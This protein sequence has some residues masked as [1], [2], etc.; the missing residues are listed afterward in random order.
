MSLES[1]RVR[2]SPH[3]FRISDFGFGI[4]LPTPVCNPQSAIRNPQSRRAFTLMEA[5]ISTVIVAVMLVTAL[6]TVGASK[7]TQHKAS[8]VSRGRMLAE[9]L[10]SEILQQSYQ[11]PGETYVFGRESGE[12]DT[13]RA[14]YDDVD[15]YHGWTES[16]PV[17]KDGTALPNSANWRRTVTVEWV[18]PLKPKTS[19]SNETGAKR[20]RIVVTFGNVPQATVVAVKVA[21]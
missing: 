9:S 6:N 13:S 10:M 14:A 1:N 3:P 12:S 7:I 20:I 19:K 16:P 8:L 11:E 15:D 4:R 2:P 5:V 21:N 17:A 18:D